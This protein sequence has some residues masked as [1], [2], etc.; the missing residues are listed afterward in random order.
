MSV[1]K[2]YFQISVINWQLSW[3]QKKF[4]VIVIT[5]ILLLSII[6]IS[7]PHY[8]QFIQ[9]RSGVLFRDEILNHIPAYNVY[10]PIFFL[11]WSSAFL[12][13]IGIIK[14]PSVFKIF[15]ISYVFL[16]LLRWISIFLFPLETPP[17]II[18]LID[19][20]TNYFYGVSFI[21]KDL[22]FSGHVSTLFLMF[23]CQRN[24]IFKYYT[25]IAS[26]CIGILVLIQHIHYSIDVIFAFPFTYLCYG[27]AKY[28]THENNLE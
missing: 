19:P 24:R 22:F 26:I 11:V 14:R 5:G 15:L 25:L 6:L 2:T 21:T 20:L 27:S 17:G 4:R 28:L 9:K 10:I 13:L 18:D 3:K 1:I 23:L 8:F 7:A 16:F 12:L